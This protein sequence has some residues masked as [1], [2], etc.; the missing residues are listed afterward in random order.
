[1]ETS[2]EGYCRVTPSRLPQCKMMGGGG[3]GGG[4]LGGHGVQEMQSMLKT[5]YG[6]LHDIV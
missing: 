5:Q 3:G 6:T 2:K 1:M 4:R